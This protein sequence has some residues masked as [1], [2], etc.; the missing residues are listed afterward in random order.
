MKKRLFRTRDDRKIFGVCGG[1]ARY[2]EID[3]TIVRIVWLA[4]VL[5]WGSGVLLYLL[6]ALII[7]D[8]PTSGQDYTEPPKRSSYVK[9][10]EP[11]IVDVEGEPAGEECRYTVISPL[12]GTAE[13]RCVG[14]DKSFLMI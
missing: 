3:S 10:D 1:I 8:T 4:L 14:S 9:T 6:A 5:L 7:P 2:L 11:E 12:N 13:V